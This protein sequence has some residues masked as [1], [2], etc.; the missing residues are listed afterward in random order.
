MNKYELS[1]FAGLMDGEGCITIYK[2]SSK[3]SRD[4]IRYTLTITIGI[5]N[6][7]IP[8]WLKFA[9]GGSIRMQ[10]RP[11]KRIM[12]NWVIEAQQA[13][14]F[15][16]MVTPYLNLKRPQAELAIKFQEQK[17][18]GRGSNHILEEAQAI[19][20]KEMKRV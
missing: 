7:W 10:K 19:L 17:R 4:K 6:E 5:S 11:P 13:L 3:T 18:K 8:Q 16:K 9:Y 12:W 1:Y 2:R 14:T 15:L 20:I